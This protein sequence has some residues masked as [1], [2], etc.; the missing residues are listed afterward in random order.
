M[1]HGSSN[2]TICQKVSITQALVDSGLHTHTHLL[3]RFCYA[4]GK[5]GGVT[6]RLY[7]MNVFIIMVLMIV[8]V[9]VIIIL[10]II[11][12]W[13]FLEIIIVIIGCRINP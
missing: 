2:H 8:I 4:L 12:L 3:K 13:W 10:L 6:T 9:I 5:R 11:W 1:R 7:S